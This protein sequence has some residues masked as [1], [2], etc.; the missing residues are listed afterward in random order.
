M[1]RAKL[2]GITAITAFLL[3]GGVSSAAVPDGNGQI[4]GCYNKLGGALKVIDVAEGDSCNP[5][6]NPIAW[7]QGGPVGPPGPAGPPGPSG[8]GGAG[9]V[10]GHIMTFHWGDI[11]PGG[12]P[13]AIVTLPGF[14]DVVALQCDS[15]GATNYGFTNTS[16]SPVM[17]ESYSNNGPT[18]VANGATISASDPG[19][20]NVVSSGTGVTSKF[21]SFAVAATAPGATCRFLGYGIIGA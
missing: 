12:Q 7:N 9:S 8:S 6:Q 14:G 20:S 16:G 3:V 17:F 11:P 21:A 5:L 18:S 19:F 13:R 10:V 15:S 2:L 1:K 4:H